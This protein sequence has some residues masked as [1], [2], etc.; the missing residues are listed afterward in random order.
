MPRRLPLL[1]RLTAV[2]ALCAVLNGSPPRASAAPYVLSGFPLLKQ[3]HSLTCE[4]SAASMGTR[5]A[6]TESQ[7]MAAIP[8]N[9]DPNFGFRGSPDGYQ[10]GDLADYGV[11]ANPVHRALLRYGYAS[12]VITYGTDDK[13]AGYVARGWPVVVWV[14]YQLRKEQ[15]RLVE[16]NGVQFFLVP[17]EHALLVVGYGPQTLV[18]N[19]PWTRQRVRYSWA[20]FNRSWGYFGNMALA[21][22]PCP[23]AAP[24]QEIRQSAL[25]TSQVKWSWK[26]AA[27]ASRYR[28]QVV[29]RGNPDVVVYQQVQTVRHVVLI[30]PNPG[31]E[32]DISVQAMSACG[33]AARPTLYSTLLPA[34]LP[35]PT[36]TPTPKPTVTP[37]VTTSSTATQTPTTAATGTPTP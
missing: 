24:V 22:A 32:Y 16:Q 29:Q 34:V 4:A 28:V 13:I 26:P 11:Y 3:Q 21:I 15:P 6:I 14:T 37:T 31:A 12:E 19:D 1:L 9:P 35:T 36:L 30:N 17:W 20:Q 7:I 8:R 18:A 33:A 10:H 25:S 2:V 23:M 27:R 5:A